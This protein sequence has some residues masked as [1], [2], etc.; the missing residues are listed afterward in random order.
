MVSEVKI[1]EILGQRPDVL[2]HLA[3]DKTIRVG[4]SV[5]DPQEKENII[6]FDELSTT[7]PT[8]D[9]ALIKGGGMYYYFSVAL[10][11]SRILTM[12]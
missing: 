10:N 5:L 1:L 9:D 6:N 4:V 7:F 8:A 3:S 12:K 11:T 2:E